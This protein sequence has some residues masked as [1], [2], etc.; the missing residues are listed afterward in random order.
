MGWDGTV[1]MM[2]IEE[3]TPLRSFNSSP[4]NL[5][6][7]KESSLPTIIS[8]FSSTK[9]CLLHWKLLSSGLF[10]LRHRNRHKEVNKTTAKK[11]GSS[12]SANMFGLSVSSRLTCIY[13]YGYTSWSSCTLLRFYIRFLVH[14]VK[15]C[16]KS[17]HFSRL[18]GTVVMLPN[19]HERLE[20]EGH[21]KIWRKWRVGD[22]HGVPSG[23]SKSL[24][25]QRQ[26]LLHIIT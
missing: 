10:L 21:V 24:L 25:R 1:G 13:I 20:V 4:D 11:T 2:F 14:Q 15:D 22:S 8:I 6:F 9:Q 23:Y 26:K 5:P 19:S 3:L 12:V 7:E 16:K 18:L 17:V